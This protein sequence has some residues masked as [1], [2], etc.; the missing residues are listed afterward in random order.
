MEFV[1][2]LPSG[3]QVTALAAVLIIFNEE[4]YK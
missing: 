2:Q 3:W 4:N 1:S